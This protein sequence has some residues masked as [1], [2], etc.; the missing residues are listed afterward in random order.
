MD[1]STNNQALKEAQRLGITFIDL[2]RD[3]AFKSIFGT[4]GNEDLLLKL[5]DA[6][7]PDRHI[8]SVELSSPEKK[9]TKP[10][11]RSAVFDIFAKTS[12]GSELII[13]MQYREQKDFNQRM[14]FY[15]SFPIQSK[16][17][18]RKDSG[19]L[20][21]NYSF[22]HV[23]VIGICNFI[24]EG[25]PS[26]DNM[27]NCYSVRNDRDT[28]I[29]FTDKVNYITVELP[30]LKKTLDELKTPADYLFYAISNIWQ[31]REMPQEYV[32]TGLEKLFELSRFAAMMDTEQRQYIAE[33]MAELDQGSREKTAWDH[34][35][36]R[37]KSETARELKRLGISTDIICQATG[38][39]PEEVAQ[40]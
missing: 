38:L 14:I 18:R 20:R 31:M 6:I 24:L 2:R 40:L 34:G 16:I 3:F 30:K 27:I 25:V 33:L 4:E 11:S 13:E 21:L 12:D 7:L 17:L 8:T 22:S 19:E 39:T 36:E 35:L 23:C 26:N 1:S 28:G 5:V 15:S 29:V 9:G 32:G 10:K 37:G